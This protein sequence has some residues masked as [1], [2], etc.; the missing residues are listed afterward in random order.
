[1]DMRTQAGAP[2]ISSSESLRSA[3]RDIG[4]IHVELAALWQEYLACEDGERRV[5]LLKAFYRGGEDWSAALGVYHAAF[6]AWRD[7]YR[8]IHADVLRYLAGRAESS[9]VIVRRLL[10]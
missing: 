5:R 10:R 4:A 3:E 8:E 2:P 1:M 7:E 9:A 6:A